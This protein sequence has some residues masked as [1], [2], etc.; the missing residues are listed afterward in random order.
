MLNRS[1]F[2]FKIR[3]LSELK[4]SESFMKKA[5]LFSMTIQYVLLISVILYAFLSIGLAMLTGVS[6]ILNGVPLSYVFVVKGLYVLCT[7]V[8]TFFFLRLIYLGEDSIF[9][10]HFKFS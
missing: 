1:K 5:R 2:A 10:K 6:A 4:K 8:G 9:K 3:P 7:F